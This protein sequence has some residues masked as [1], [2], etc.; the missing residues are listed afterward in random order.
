MEGLVT[1]DAGVVDDDVDSAE[2][3]DRGIDDRLAA[4][5]G[6]HRVVVGHCLAACRD[7]LVDHELGGR[8]VVALAAD[9][10]AQ[11]VHH[12]PR[13]AARELERV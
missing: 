9:R 11:V 6:R 12:D 8:G 7:D 4:L 5:G 2:R 13:A 10:A 1:Q 3:L